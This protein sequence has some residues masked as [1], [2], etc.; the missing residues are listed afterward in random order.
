MNKLLFL[1]DYTRVLTP[2][3]KKVIS[4]KPGEKT[5]LQSSHK[6]SFNLV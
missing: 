2:L 1:I 4:L 5:R 6:I 3:R